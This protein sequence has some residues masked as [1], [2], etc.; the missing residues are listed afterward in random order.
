MVKLHLGVNDEARKW[1]VESIKRNPASDG[2]AAIAGCCSKLRVVPCKL[3]ESQPAYRALSL[4]R[5]VL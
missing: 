1:S 2:Q 3:M 4:A 5:F